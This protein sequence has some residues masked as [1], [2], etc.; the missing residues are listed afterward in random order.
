VALSATD[1]VA[2]RPPSTVGVNVAAIVQL[3]PAA[4]VPTVRQSVPL[5]GV[6]NAKSAAF[7]PPN[8]TLEM[9]SDPEPELVKTDVICAAVVFKR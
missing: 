2:L 6:A 7:V 8:V 1:T 3:A 4:T 5:A 9:A